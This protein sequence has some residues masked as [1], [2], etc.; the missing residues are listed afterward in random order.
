MKLWR[1]QSLFVDAE[2]GIMM[3]LVVHHSNSLAKGSHD[4]QGAGN[5]IQSAQE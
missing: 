3:K 5:I 4:K 1:V 2:R